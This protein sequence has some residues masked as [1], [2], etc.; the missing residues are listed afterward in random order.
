MIIVVLV[1]APGLGPASRPQEAGE[2]DTPDL[3]G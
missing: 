2:H 1:L 3:H